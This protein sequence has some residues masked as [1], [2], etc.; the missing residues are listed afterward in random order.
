MKNVIA[1]LAFV[2]VSMTATSAFAN[3]PELVNQL[4]SLAQTG[5]VEKAG[6][7]AFD[8]S[9]TGGCSKNDKRLADYHHADAYIFQSERTGRLLD[10]RQLRKISRIA[11]SWRVSKA[12]G[13]LYFSDRNMPK[14]ARAFDDA[15]AIAYGGQSRI[16]S[17]ATL[18]LLEKRAFQARAL[19]P[20][21]INTA[22]SRA[23]AVTRIKQRVASGEKYSINVPVRFDYNSAELSHEGRRAAQDI[24]GQLK[25][26]SEPDVYLIGH[27][28]PSG[29]NE[30][31]LRLS[32][33]RAESMARFLTSRNYAGRIRVEGRGENDRFIPAADLH[34]TEEELHTFDRRVEFVIGNN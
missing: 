25:S 9:L 4:E 15:L 29:S 5:D 30:Y 19:S 3:C 1:T 33:L 11:R 13:D 26:F 31:N 6:D 27:T 32:R 34:F 21:Y 28:D 24:Y 10:V 2:A 22:Q 7:L 14:A 18:D 12:L 17:T 16:T 20:S 8:I 23:I